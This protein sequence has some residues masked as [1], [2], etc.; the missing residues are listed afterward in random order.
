[1]SIAGGVL[2]ACHECDL[3]QHEPRLPRGGTARCRRCGATLLRHHPYG[4][5]RA[6]ACILGALILF[7][8]AN[9]FPIVSLKLS[10]DF[11]QTTLLGAAQAMYRHD[12]TMVAG[13]VLITT[14]LAP[15]TQM[16]AM[17]YLLLP[18]FFK[19]RPPYARL[20]FRGL[21]LA[22][23]W[24]MLEVF[25]LGILVSLVKLAHLAQML[26]GIALWSFGAVMLLMAAAAS[27]FDSRAL[28][29]RLE[30]SP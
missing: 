17:I 4:N 20:I 28:W 5:E 3:L 1:M 26:P 18:A 13:L 6:L 8:L 21:R 16:L 12:M 29:V 14:F 22:Q 24:G 27:S 7:V 11:I 10:G 15:L 19:R 9:V 23:P 25:V 30:S 2:V